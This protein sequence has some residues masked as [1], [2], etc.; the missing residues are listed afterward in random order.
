MYPIAS[1]GASQAILDARAIADAL[2]RGPDV[3]AALREYEAARRPPTAEIVRMNREQ[4]PDVIL[5]M[6]HERAPGGFRTI[7]DL[8]PRQDLPPIVPPYH[9]PPA[10]PH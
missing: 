1:N 5:D 7:A 4:G 3:Q 10:H 6:V 2:A 9:L 8:V